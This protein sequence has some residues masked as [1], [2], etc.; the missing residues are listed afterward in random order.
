M[1]NSLITTRLLLLALVLG[2]LSPLQA[3]YKVIYNFGGPGEPSCPG[4]PTISQTPGGNLASTSQ[5]ACTGGQNGAAFEVGFQ[6]ANFTI[7]HDFGTMQPAGGLT[8]GTD[9]RFHGT[10][11]LGGSRN[12]GTVFRLSPQPNLVNQ[13]DFEGGAD[14]A[15]PLSAP[16]QSEAGDFYGTTNG[17][18]SH[19]AGTIYKIEK[20]GKYSVLHLFTTTDGRGPQAPLVQG[21]DGYF[22]GTT[23]AGGQ[24]GL[25]TIFRI[26]STG[27]FKVLYQFDGTKGK[28]PEGPLIQAGDGDFYGVTV[29]GGTLNQG[30]A[31]KMTPSGTVTVLYDFSLTAADGNEP[32]GGLVEATDGNF[33]GTLLSGGAGGSGSIYRLTPAGVFTKL[34]DFRSQSGSFPST[35]MEHTSGKLYGI[36]T[37]GGTNSNGVI[38]EYD[39]GLGPFVTFLNVYGQVGAQVNILGEYFAEGVTTVY[40]NGVPA[41]NPVITPTYITAT[42][43]AGA[44]TGLITVTTTKGTLSSNH[45]FVVH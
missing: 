26:T 1:E 9:Q 2:G 19:Y 15:F 35:L 22:Y 18:A 20:S 31:F 14:G 28:V 40:F 38:F 5:S 42:V 4:G 32:I 23:V 21:S 7:L 11:E 16:I 33:Y 10:T 3:Q 36:T 37:Q 25:G 39:P 30:V 12:H 24:Y 8:F 17:S 34:H 41:Q 29:Q 45:P 44:T 13:H 27:D 43:P 6:G